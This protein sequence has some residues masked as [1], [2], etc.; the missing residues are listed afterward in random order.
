MKL[1]DDVFQRL[2]KAVNFDRI[3]FLLKAEKRVAE[4]ATVKDLVFFAPKEG[5]ISP[6]G[7][8]ERVVINEVLAVTHGIRD[9]ITAKA[10]PEVIEEQ[11]KKEG[12]FTML[13]DGIFKAAC[14]IT[15]VEE[16][17]RVIAE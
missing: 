13:E 17:L 14:G 16:V 11:A 3:L 4:N 6:D 10:T 12:M 9:L 2:S 15:T 5:G 8:S 7:Y 1:T